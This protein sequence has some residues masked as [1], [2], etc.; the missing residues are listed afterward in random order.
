MQSE[1]NAQVRA[2][3]RECRQR[4]TSRQVDNEQLSRKSQHAGA[5]TQDSSCAG[6]NDLEFTSGQLIRGADSAAG[7]G[8][9]DVED[10]AASWSRW[11]SDLPGIIAG[12]EDATFG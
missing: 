12:A 2:I 7:R 11:M 3:A 10:A 1:K 5:R 6:R 9:L 8:C 4:A